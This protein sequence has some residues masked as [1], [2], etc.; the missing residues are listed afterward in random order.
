VIASFTGLGC[1]VMSPPYG[2]AWADIMI[3]TYY[4]NETLVR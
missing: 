4:Y 1:A 2:L 3:I